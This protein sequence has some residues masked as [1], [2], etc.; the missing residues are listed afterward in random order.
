MIWQMKPA[1]VS[2]QIRKLNKEA[3]VV[4]QCFLN[5]DINYFL[6]IRFLFVSTESKCK[7]IWKQQMNL[8][9][10]YKDIF[11]ATSSSTMH[12]TSANIEKISSL[13]LASRIKLS[14]NANQESSHDGT[15]SAAFQP[16]VTIV[17]H[18]ARTSQS[19]ASHTQYDTMTGQNN[20]QMVILHE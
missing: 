20:S 15:L 6:R 8:P 9:S 13:R 3:H 12:N 14:S 16:V 5:V 10:T 11:V 19:F 17:K 18:R 4:K 7:C 2:M 1:M